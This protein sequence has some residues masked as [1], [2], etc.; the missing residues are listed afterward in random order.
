MRS[1]TFIILSLIIHIIAVAAVALAPQRTIEPIGGQVE[2]S[3]GEPAETAGAVEAPEQVTTS[4][5]PAP[6]LKPVAKKAPAPKKAPVVAKQPEPVQEVA[7][8]EE[9][10]ELPPKEEVAQEKAEE[11]TP[12]IQNMDEVA[13]QESSDEATEAA[14]PEA[15]PANPE[16]APEAA[17]ATSAEGEGTG[18]LGKGGA[19]QSQA[20]AY[21][22]L[23]QDKGN[24]GPTYPLKARKEMRQ[25]QVDLVYRVT[26]DG[27]VTDVQ[28]AKSSGHEDLDQAALKS[29]SKFRFV[30]SQEGW[31]YHPVLFS[32]KGESTPLPGKLRTAGGSAE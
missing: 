4:P 12:E 21:T 14:S 9:V 19:T 15:A 26:K 7:K 10:A 24:K 5:A 11:L 17:Q 1:S 2:M 23:K 16:P 13:K 18:D 3:V 27:R 31:A 22:E 28:I 29:V 20:V 32:L 8:T 25:G 6:K 30:P